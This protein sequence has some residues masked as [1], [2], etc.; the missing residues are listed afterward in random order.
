[1]VIRR[2]AFVIQKFHRYQKIVHDSTARFKVVVA[3]RRWG[4]TAFSRIQLILAALRKP[5]ALVWYIA[6]TYSMAHD[7]MWSSLLEAIPPSYI[8]KK[9]DTKMT[10]VLKNGSV[11]QCKGADKPDS[12]RGR[13]V[14]YVVLDE[15]QDFKE[16]AWEAAIFPT[17]TDRRGHALIIG[18]PKAYN[19][20]YKL[21]EKGQSTHKDDQDWAS[22][23]FPTATSPFI[24]KSELSA[25]RRNL[26]ERTYKQE[27]EASFETM[28]GRVYY[29]FD[30][31]VHV[32]DYPF[33]PENYIIVGQDFNVDPM[34]SVILQY[35]KRSGEL[36]A[37]D[38]IYLNQSNTQEV[39]D[40]LE[41]RYW[42][43]F[44]NNVAV[45]PDPAGANRSS[46]RGETD[47]QIFREKRIN[48][49][50]Y[51]KKHPFVA[52]RINAVNAMLRSADGQVRLKID[53]RCKRLI[54]S[55]EQTIYRAGTRDIDKALGAEHITDALGYPIELLFS[56]TR[57]EVHGASW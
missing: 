5:K 36:W 21:Y 2:S 42:R 53:K 12:L 44:P 4:K 55:L 28:S 10:V 34:C 54:E 22:W 27:Y 30:R 57:V 47:I 32:G 13:G 43:L 33:D 41:R 1:M 24:P 31:N 20:L 50:H 23:Q 7:I 49:I 3:G 38:E 6:P 15:Y 19:A 29:P 26:D 8:L 39:V 18:T 16:D 40:E 51:R 17:L 9:N 48:R 45:F 35:K 52:D 37:I 25:A 46:A 56:P 14:D 11:I